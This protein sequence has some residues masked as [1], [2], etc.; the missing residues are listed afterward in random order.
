MITFSIIQKSQLEGAIRID[1]EYYQPEF[2]ELVSRIKSQESKLLKNYSDQVFS[3]PFG[4]MLK[5]ESYRD[6]GIPFIR[7]GDISDIFISRENLV[8]ISEEEHKRIFST[9][10]D[11]GDI[12]LSKIG[13]VGRLSV[14]S[15]D[16]GQ[17][18][19]SEN[20]IGVR[21]SVLPPEERAGLLFFLL[22]RYGQS[23]ILRNASGN[24][25][26]KLNVADIE[27]ISIPIFSKQFKKDLHDFYQEIIELRNRSSEI[28]QQAENLLLGELGLEDFDFEKI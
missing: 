15:D 22:G 18:N 7:I 11:P 23:Q 9:H 6:E 26:L 28:Y 10:L 3:G 8:Y 4:S 16:L 2:L 27:N 21:L 13:T 5:S 19:I 1:A 12:V 14:I 25:Q 17:V 20:N 24:I